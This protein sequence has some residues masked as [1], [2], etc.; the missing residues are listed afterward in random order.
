MTEIKEVQNNIF[1]PLTL[2]DSQ[3]TEYIKNK[4]LFYMDLLEGESFSFTKE[5]ILTPIKKFKYVKEIIQH[6]NLKKDIVYF[7][8]IKNHA[9][10][11]YDAVSF[12]NNIHLSY[13]ELN[14]LSSLSHISILPILNN[15]SKK[16]IARSINSFSTSDCENN[17]FLINR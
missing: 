13:L 9:I 11:L 3:T 15:E 2:K 17:M 7:A 12:S 14:V 10:Y 8:I 16:I 5:L 6:S 4:E 1:N